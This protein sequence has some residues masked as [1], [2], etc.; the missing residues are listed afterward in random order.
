[1]YNGTLFIKLD[2]G[3]VYRVFVIDNIA[4]SVEVMIEV[5]PRFHRQGSRQWRWMKKDG[6]TFKKVAAVAN[7]KIAAKNDPR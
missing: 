3:K 1:M 7:A 2:N 4:D 5:A 6:P